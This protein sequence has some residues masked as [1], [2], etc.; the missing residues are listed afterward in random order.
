MF[1]EMPKKNPRFEDDA[2]GPLERLDVGKLMCKDCVYRRKDQKLGK[3]M[4]D[5]AA[6]DNC[7]AYDSKPTS[8]LFDGGDCPYY[9]SEKEADE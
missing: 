7:D 1:H 2:V 4:F 9:L 5:G 6:F 3:T 8:V